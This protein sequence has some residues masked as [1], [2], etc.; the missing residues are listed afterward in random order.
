MSGLPLRTSHRALLMCIAIAANVG[1]TLPF[2]T[3]ASSRSTRACMHVWGSEWNQDE[4]RH[5]R[6][7]WGQVTDEQYEEQSNAE[8]YHTFQSQSTHIQAN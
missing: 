5:R 1:V 2:G 8:L 7:L 6:D 3:V 4:S